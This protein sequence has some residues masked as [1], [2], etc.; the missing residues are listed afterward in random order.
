MVFYLF[1]IQL[2]IDG[3]VLLLQFVGCV[4]ICKQIKLSE[5]KAKLGVSRLPLG[6]AACL[7]LQHPV[8]LIV[9]LLW[10]WCLGLPPKFIP[11]VFFKSLRR[12]EP[13]DL[14]LK[15]SD[16]L[17]LCNRGENARGFY[18]F[19]IMLVSRLKMNYNSLQLA[20]GWNA[21]QTI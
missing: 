18:T 3:K 16:V 6:P 9:P 11:V 10:F 20:W 19:M 1:L 15:S 5:V 8:Q 21:P 2:A 4:L 14:Q 12:C 13:P 17:I 7:P